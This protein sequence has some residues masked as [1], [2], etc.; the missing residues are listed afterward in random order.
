MSGG[1]LVVGVVVVGWGGQR[2][3][4]MVRVGGVFMSALSFEADDAVVRCAWCGRLRYVLGEFPERVFCWSVGCELAR[5][6][7]DLAMEEERSPVPRIEF[8]VRVWDELE[9]LTRLI[10][11]GPQLSAVPEQLGL[12]A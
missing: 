1:G 2:T 3:G 9:S 5:Q 4:W 12:V 8:C 10:G 11:R 7:F 6:L